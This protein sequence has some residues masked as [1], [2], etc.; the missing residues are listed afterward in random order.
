M[1]EN[2]DN[3]DLIE[4]DGV[5]YSRFYLSNYRESATGNYDYEV[6]ES[7]ENEV[8]R[9]KAIKPDLIDSVP[10]QEPHV[11]EKVYASSNTDKKPNGS[12]KK[13]KEKRKHKFAIVF[14]SILLCCCFVLLIADSFTDGYILD[15]AS[16]ILFNKST[17]TKTYYA[18]EIA[19][20][21]DFNSAK[22]CSSEIRDMDGA[23][24]VVND[25][26]F[27]V[28]ADVYDSKKDAMSVS[29]KLN[30]SGYLS[31]IYVID[32]VA[33]DYSTLPMSTR[34]ISKKL[35]GY[36]DDVYTKLHEVIIN[37]EQHNM[38]NATALI[39]ITALRD[40]MKEKLVE[41][42]TNV[43]NDIDNPNVLK[44]R[45]QLFA[46]I[47]GLEN[48]INLKVTDKTFLSDIRYTSIMVLN[49]HRAMVASLA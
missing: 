14:I 5:D 21:T 45:M 39:E 1:S 37:L 29:S 6:I 23:G 16:K 8:P 26:L 7:E 27:R 47:G 22:V 2:Y 44:I 40:G 41:Y 31:K 32:I 3:E 30:I 43:D 17:T 15:T 28:I 34:N 4:E 9:L 11:V 12:N 24:Y 33:P 10:Y 35:L 46:V 48:L 25:E 19:S 18:V 36:Y 38:D 20:F 49:T 13:P 42:E